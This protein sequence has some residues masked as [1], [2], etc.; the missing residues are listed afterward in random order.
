MRKGQESE[1]HTFEGGMNTDDDLTV[2][3]PNQY[4]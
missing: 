2:L 1:V 3:K 4:R